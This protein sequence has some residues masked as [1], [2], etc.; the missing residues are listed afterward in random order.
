[1]L[2]PMGGEV[3]EAVDFD[4]VRKNAAEQGVELRFITIKYE[5]LTDDETDELTHKGLLT[6]SIKPGTALGRFM[7]NG[8]SFSQK[9]LRPFLL[10]GTDSCR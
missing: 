4:A 10:W 8:E 2:R 7:D 6:H 1:M 3:A 5:N 9:R